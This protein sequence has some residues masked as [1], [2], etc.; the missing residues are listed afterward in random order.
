[1]SEIGSWIRNRWDF[2][3]AA[4][5]ERR[6]L[7]ASA[8]EPDAHRRLILLTQAARAIGLQRRFDEAN[9]LLDEV[10]AQRDDLDGAGRTFLH[11]ERGRVLNS[12]SHADQA[13]P[14]FERALEEAGAAG[15][16]D[17]AV[18]AAHMLGIASPD[19]QA[20]LEWNLRAIR[21]AEASEDPDA[22]RWLPSLLNNTASS[23]HDLG[24]FDEALALFQ[25]AVPLREEAGVPRPVFI[26][27]WSVAR[28]LRSLGRWNEARQMQ[29]SLLREMEASGHLD[30]FVFEELAEL[31]LLEGEPAAGYAAKAAE[32]LAADPWVGDSEPERI[33]RLRTIAASV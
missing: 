5:S 29:E 9:A 8:D 26:A 2:E 11:L 19:P 32:L 21:M 27:R 23:L 12:S 33:E 1:M 31:A 24:R 28:C 6:F 4:G 18:D 16:D 25:R 13:L 20:Q 15:L 14:C 30:G 3:D 17:L 7:S 22:R 10:A